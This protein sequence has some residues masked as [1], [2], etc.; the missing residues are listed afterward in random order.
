MQEQL[1]EDT[2]GIYKL[3]DDS[4]KTRFI[5]G[6]EV[7][8]IKKTRWANAPSAPAYLCAFA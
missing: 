6:T 2:S 1:I 3:R 8:S 7:A 4:S 5:I